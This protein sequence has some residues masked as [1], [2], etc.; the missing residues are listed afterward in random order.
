M[1]CRLYTAHIR[2]PFGYMLFLSM[3]ISQPREFWS[4]HRSSSIQTSSSLSL[5]LLRYLELVICD[6]IP[7]FLAMTMIDVVIIIT[8]PTPHAYLSLS[9]YI[10]PSKHHGLL[11]KD[12]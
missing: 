12:Q 7:S 3:P 11:I 8:Q 4:D 6:R 1:Y 5:R 2:D 9:Q 10:F